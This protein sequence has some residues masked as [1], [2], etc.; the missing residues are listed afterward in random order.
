MDRRNF[1]FGLGALVGGLVIEQAIPLGRVW[2]FPTTLAGV[3]LTYDDLADQTKIYIVP[4]LVDSV[5]IASPMFQR[6]RSASGG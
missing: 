5:F 6:L 2:S 1:I 4:K 3:P